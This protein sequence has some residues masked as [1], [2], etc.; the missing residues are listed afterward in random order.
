M[1]FKD[2]NFDTKAVHAG[3]RVD[4]DY[5]TLATPVYQTSTF[6]FRDADHAMGVFGGSISGYDYSRAGNPTVRVFEEKMMELEG[7]EDA[8]ATSSGMGAISSTL[9]SILKAND[10]IVTSNTLYGC[11][12]IV[13]REI[14]PPFGIETTFVDT[15]NLDEIRNAIKENTKMI[16]FESVANP[17][18]D[19][20]D[21]E[22][23]SKLAHEHKDI[24]VVCD[25]TFTPPPI[26]NP[27]SLGAD[28]VVHSATKYL[29]GHGDV[30][31]G[32]VLGRSEDIEIIRSKGM[33]KICG[34][35]LD[36]HAAYLIVRGLK[37]LGLRVRR[38][39]ESALK[40]AEFLENHKYVE[41]VHY[42]GLS[43]NGKNYEVFKKMNDKLFTGIMSFEVKPVG[44]MS[45]LEVAKHVMNNLEIVSIAVSLGDPD[46]LIEHPYT[47]THGALSEETK[48][49]AGINEGL[50]RFSVGLEDVDDLVEDFKRAFDSLEE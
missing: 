9:L 42:A 31:C 6:V 24:K 28:I 11:S 21:I 13:M 22:M 45:A 18:M 29:N 17:T 41:K 30:I 5:G 32:I 47:M 12:D 27:I 40:L 38:H 8:V 48:K 4:T 1:N 19:V 14:L 46:S 34:T 39:C 23:I 44:K 15:T 43:S 37:T 3:F 49:K 16:Y 36:P 35:P 2:K 26:V 20:S 10:H 33:G 50:L 25:S 7:A